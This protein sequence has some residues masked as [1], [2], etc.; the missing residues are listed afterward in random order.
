MKDLKALKAKLAEITANAK[1]IT[2]AAKTEKRDLTDEQLGQVN[3]FLNEA[4]T[5]KAEIT[6]G[7]K[8]LEAV[9]KVEALDA[10][11]KTSKGRKT[12]H[13]QL[14]GARSL[15][16]EIKNES[17]LTSGMHDRVLD[18]AKRGFKNLG[19]FAGSVHGV[20]NGGQPDERLRI[21]G[22]AGDPT[23][24]QSVGAD[25]GFLVPPSFSST[26]YDG[27]Q[28]DPQSLLAL[29]DQYTIPF[30]TDSMTFP[31][32]AETSRADGS[33]R[34]G[35][36]G[37]WKSELGQMTST[38]VTFREI[39]LEPQQLY[40][41]SYVSDKLLRNATV[42]EQYL[43]KAAAEEIA[44]KINNAIISGT[45]AGQPKGVMSSGALISVTKET[46]QAADTIVSANIHKMWQRAHPQAKRRGVW[47]YDQSCEQ[48]LSE[49]TINV[50][51][52]G[53]PLMMP[54]GGLSSAP[55]GTIKGR[56]AMPSEFSYALG[57]N[58]DILFVDLGSY[59]V[60]LRGGVDTAMSMHLKFDYA[61]SAFRFLFEIDGQP[62]LASA[63]TPFTPGGTTKTETL[64]AFTAI[65]ARA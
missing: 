37:Y 11:L 58:G 25:G 14:G 41:F 27:L 4:E 1:A 38:K 46:G 18:D 51:T 50:G 53:M 45:G 43:N 19:E 33:R 64:S 5:V 7:E 47:L 13:D 49:L 17:V 34:G 42:L 36:Q 65:A 8:E 2:S 22:A 55:Y 56:P 62:W 30:G 23:Q 54:P 24:Q 16:D 44:F 29:C 31:A 61:Q 6:A 39:K 63:L 28:A 10:D 12:A 26:I 32:N 35:I 20:A 52:G 15:S 9:R 59:A 48:Q 21:M 3:A 60:G 57:D 40:V